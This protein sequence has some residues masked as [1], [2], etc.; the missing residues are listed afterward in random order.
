MMGNSH[1]RD[2][3]K[4]HSRAP[5][6]GHLPIL[7]E[8]RRWLRQEFTCSNENKVAKSNSHSTPESHAMDKSKTSFL[9]LPAEIRNN[10]YSRVLVCQGY[11]RL[12]RHKSTK[13]PALVL[14][15]TCKQVHEEAASFFYAA[16]SFY[17]Q[18]NRTVC[19]PPGP[20][21]SLPTP[22]ESQIE[23][24]PRSLDLK[25][26]GV[27]FPARRYHIWMTRLTIDATIRWG[28]E[29]TNVGT[30]WDSYERRDPDK[31]ID[32]IKIQEELG[33]LFFVTYTKIKALWE[34]K[35]AKW[36]GRMVGL[37]DHSWVG[38]LTAAD[39]D[40]FGT[41]G[42]W[43]TMRFTISFSEEEEDE[44]AMK[45]GLRRWHLRG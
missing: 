29:G 19:Y 22:L 36:S 30:H 45:G 15:R 42:G 32:D 13:V 8:P 39:E 35:D 26:G 2:Q 4:T 18:A 24:W 41:K 3:A 38:L 21:T 1:S 23:P 44:L 9:D 7:H 34:Q 33:S 20:S 31:C 37:V 17:C 11:V 10:I 5:K 43:R 14:L 6:H 40:E 16:N 12:T 27:F 28:G 25:N